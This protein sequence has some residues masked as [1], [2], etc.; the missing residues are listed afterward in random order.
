[1][2]DETEGFSGREIAK[3]AI[4]WQAAAY[5]TPD[6]SFNPE[7]MFEVLE[8]KIKCNK[9]ARLEEWQPSAD[10]GLWL[11]M[12]VG[13]RMIS[14]FL[15][16]VACICFVLFLFSLLI[17]ALVFLKTH[18]LP[19]RSDTSLQVMTDLEIG[20]ADFDEGLSCPFTGSLTCPCLNARSLFKLNRRT[21][22]R[23]DRSKRG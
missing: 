5:G 14:L 23:S 21:C 10:K 6:S 17:K 18:V 19:Q 4:A 16:V 7:L 13:F 3:L 11:M 2:A 15:D 1:M 12:T 22:S 9:N 8:V 20:C